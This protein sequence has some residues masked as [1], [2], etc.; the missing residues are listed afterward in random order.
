MAKLSTKF[1]CQECGYES[2]KWNGRCPGCGQWN[3]FVEEV[4]APRARAHAA[5]NQAV[6]VHPLPIGD[7]PSQQERRFTT[8][9]AETDRVLGGGVVAGSLVLI[10]GDPGIG[11]ST[12]LL[13]LSHHLAAAGKK[14]LYVSGKS[15]QRS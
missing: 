3:T 10:G 15:P 12:L 4:A 9:M 6:R 13:Q 2:V 1:V 7:I 5:E 8:G 14:V 11:K